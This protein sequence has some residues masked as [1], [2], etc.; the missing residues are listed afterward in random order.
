V[1]GIDG[2]LHRVTADLKRAGL[3]ASALDPEDKRSASE[4]E[5]VVR[6]AYKQGNIMLAHIDLEVLD[7][8]GIYAHLTKAGVDASVLDPE[9]KRTAA[10]MDEAIRESCRK[11]DLAV[12]RS[13]E[14]H[15]K[16]DSDRFAKSQ[17]RGDAILIQAD[18]RQRDAA[19]ARAAMSD[20]AFKAMVASIRANAVTE[21]AATEFPTRPS[22]TI[23]E[24]TRG[25]G[26]AVPRR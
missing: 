11:T 8:K 7:I 26:T 5:A 21:F 22:D 2:S 25:G 4:M 12:A 6:E 15:L 17:D 10:Q 3:D 18:Q 16:I 13:E 19:L 23:P 14:D 24:K 9:H 20:D 1:D